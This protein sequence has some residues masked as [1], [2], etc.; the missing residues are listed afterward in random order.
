MTKQR[1]I[2]QLLPP[3][4]VSEIRVLHRVITYSRPGILPSPSSTVVGD[5]KQESKREKRLLPSAFTGR[6]AVQAAKLSRTVLYSTD[7]KVELVHP[8][9]FV[10]APQL[11]GETKHEQ[12]HCVA[13]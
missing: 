10:F 5:E 12:K 1:P 6:R 8:H 2:F 11:K 7:L 9:V 3:R 4:H 13:F